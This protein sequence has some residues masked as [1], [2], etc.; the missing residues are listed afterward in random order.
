MRYITTAALLLAAACAPEARPAHGGWS[1]DAI[2]YHTEECSVYHCEP[3]SDTG[4]HW[5]ETTDGGYFPCDAPGDCAG[6]RSD[7]TDRCSPFVE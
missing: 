2:G 4:L 6:A 3:E 1:C 5:Y 7:A